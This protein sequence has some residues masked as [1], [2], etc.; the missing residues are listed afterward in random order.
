[1]KRRKALFAGV[2]VAA[3]AAGLGGALWR[4]R[5]AAA[6]EALDVAV[7]SRTFEQPNGQALHLADLRGKPLLLNFWATW[8]P[9][10]L[11]EMPLLDRFHRDQQA[12][13]WQVVGLAIDNKDAVS[14]FLSERPVTYPIGL[15][16]FAGAE[17]ARTLGNMGGGLPFTVIFHRSG[18]LAEHKLGLVKPSDLADWTSRMR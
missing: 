4:Q 15:A 7:W 13:G 12:N 6:T 2:A 17:L 5:R 9:P 18:A 16:G 10:C 3:G 8:C 1:M 14:R 11:K